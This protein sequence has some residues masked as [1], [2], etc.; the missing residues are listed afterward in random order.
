MKKQVQFK[1]LSKC[2]LVLLLGMFAV[3]TYGQGQN[4][5]NVGYSFTVND[6]RYEITYLPPPRQGTIDR[7]Q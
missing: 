2:C 5:V 7:P 6:S 1:T 4:E 3:T